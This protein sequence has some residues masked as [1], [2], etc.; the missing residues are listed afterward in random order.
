MVSNESV[1]NVEASGALSGEEERELRFKP[2]RE[3]SVS[4]GG[5]V[6]SLSMLYGLLMRLPLSFPLPFPTPCVRDE[7][8]A[9]VLSLSE[10]LIMIGSAALPEGCRDVDARDFT[11]IRGAKKEAGLA[12][13]R[14]ALA[15]EGP[16]TAF[17]G[18]KLLSRV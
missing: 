5:R 4:L 6:L 17:A 18:E 7:A 15:L 2:M 16:A 1:P 3:V 9:P 14:V 10:S 13:V 11:L 8:T 12:G